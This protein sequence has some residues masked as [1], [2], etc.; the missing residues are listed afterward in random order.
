TVRFITE[1]DQESVEDSPG[2]SYCEVDECVHREPGDR[3]RASKDEFV[4]A[5]FRPAGLH[6]LCHEAARLT[7]IDDRLRRR[8]FERIAANPI[9]DVVPAAH[10]PYVLV[11]RPSIDEL[12]RPQAD[13]RQHKC[14]QLQR[15]TERGEIDALQRPRKLVIE[16]LYMRP[17][18]ALDPLIVVDRNE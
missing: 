16:S 7:E 9:D 13:E 12:S 17:Q 5:H 14:A 2:K 10:S 11:L 15:T 6:V 1:P 8:H 3:L 4:A 18:S